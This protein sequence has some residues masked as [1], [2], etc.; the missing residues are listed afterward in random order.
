MW[1][2]FVQYA[3]T[4]SLSI[5]D[6]VRAGW[7]FCGDYLF[8]RV[9]G[10]ELS[11]DLHAIAQ[12][13]IDKTMWRFA[14]RNIELQNCDASQYL[15]PEDMTVAYMYHPFVGPPFKKMIDNIEKSYARNR[16]RI[17]IFY[18]NPIMHDYVSSREW[19][20]TRVYVQGNVGVYGQ[21]G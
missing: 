7:C 17:T 21:I 11:K 18:T 12:V 15:V 20:A 8:K 1:L 6:Q 4:T 16:R 5:L 19:L 14:C 3:A 9:I 2:G 10:V 13:N